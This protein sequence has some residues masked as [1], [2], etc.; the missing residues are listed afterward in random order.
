MADCDPTSLAALN[1]VECAENLLARDSNGDEAVLEAVPGIY[2]TPPDGEGCT[3]SRDGSDERPIFLPEMPLKAKAA[4]GVFVLGADGR[5]YGMI[6]PDP[7]VKNVLV[8][9]AGASFFEDAAKSRTVFDKESIEHALGC[10]FKFA[11]L[12]MCD[13][14]G[15]YKLRYATRDEVLGC[16]A[17][18]DVLEGGGIMVCEDGMKIINPSSDGQILVSDG[19]KWKLAR[20]GWGFHIVDT[21]FYTGYGPVVT[22]NFDDSGIPGQ[23][24]GRQIY[25]ELEIWG[26]M[27]G[28]GGTQVGVYIDGSLIQL[29]FAGNGGADQ[30]RFRYMI[31]AEAGGSFT[32]QFG[33]YSGSPATANCFAKIIG[34]WA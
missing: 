10:D 32:F 12:E 20:Q 4:A 16:D 11:I 3:Q 22:V 25:A 19:G 6:P 34:Y 26:T 28:T 1:E 24:A 21:T 23:V 9:E 30:Q 13:G 17:I 2:M 7:T 15:S 8:H 31:P 18:E 29:F 14:S 33:P 5:L 27:A